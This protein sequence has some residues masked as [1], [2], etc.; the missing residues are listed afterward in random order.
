MSGDKGSVGNTHVGS[1]ADDT[2]MFAFA[3]NMFSG[4]LSGMISKTVGAPVDRV[5]LILQTQA[6]NSDVTQRYG[7]LRDTFTRIYKEQGILSFW[8]GNGA[9]LIRYYPH[10]ALSFAFKDKF[11]AMST[12]N[13]NASD[14]IHE[15]FW[16]VVAR[17]I[18][19]AGLGGGLSLVLLYPLDMARTRLAADVGSSRRGQV[20]SRRFN[21]TVDCLRKI[22]SDSGLRGIYT[23]LSV[24]ITGVVIFRGLFMGGYDTV[25]YALGLDGGG[26]DIDTGIE[27]TGAQVKNEFYGNFTVN[28]LK[29]LVAAQ[30][31][32]LTAGTLCYPIDTVRRRVMMQSKINIVPAVTTVTNMATVATAASAAAA[33]TTTFKYRGAIH[34]LAVILKEEGVRGLYSGLSA[35]LIRGIAGPILLVSYDVFRMGLSV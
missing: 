33:S 18:A 20:N 19:S 10:M 25:K 21:G 5:K 17:N 14:M 9:N 6:V 11:K 2:S 35:N 30:V 16:K 8:R 15:P 29:R 31:V 4:G 34:A 7:G 27:K 28:V 1:A 26:I 13:A 12:S 24:S 22:Y 3:R 23:G 32:T